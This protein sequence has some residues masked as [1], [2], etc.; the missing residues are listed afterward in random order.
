MVKNLI[1]NKK[2][3]YKSTY[4][5]SI[6]TVNKAKKIVG[7]LISQHKQEKICHN[8]QG[9]VFAL[10]VDSKKLLCDNKFCDKKTAF[11]D[12]LYKSNFNQEQIHQ[13]IC[14]IIDGQQLTEIVNKLNL[15]KI[16]V[17]KFRELIIEQVD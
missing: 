12:P 14:M 15:K 10:E 16:I 5:P 8:C 9:K 13:L 1:K 6:T 3:N 17:S 4:K 2:P 7:D 11:V